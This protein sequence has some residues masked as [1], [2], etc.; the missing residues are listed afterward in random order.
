MG[1]SR[2]F[3]GLSLFTVILSIGLISGTL[4]SDSDANRLI[5]RADDDQ[6][7]NDYLPE[8]TLILRQRLVELNGSALDTS[9]SDLIIDLFDDTRLIATDLIVNQVLGNGKIW[10]GRIKGS[11]SG[12][13]IIS[14]NDDSITATVQ[15][16][17]D[18]YHIRYFNADFSVVRQIDPYEFG[19]RSH[20]L[21][22]TTL[23][24]TGDTEFETEVITLTNQER[25]I[26]NLNSLSIDSNLTT[27]ARQHSIDLADN[28]L[29][30]HIGSD[31]ST[32]FERITDAG[33]DSAY[34]GENV[35]AGYST[36]ELVVEGWMSSSGHR[37]NILNSDFC[38][39]GVGYAYNASSTYQH[40]WTQNF[41][42]K[43]GVTTCEPNASESDDSGELNASEADDST[44]G[45]FIDSLKN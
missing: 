7:Q 40:Y 22:L 12:Q 3:R 19:Q 16:D 33:Y 18:Y 14:Q 39:I 38:D 34:T 42:R 13:I 24:A 2:S 25:S 37:A 9:F 23:K 4:Y 20:I 30:G 29:E 15:T 32:P 8:N 28:D 6:V 36:P 11:S 44:G 21:T 31:G 41:G 5:I 27:S 1:I 10:T 17:E 26:E 43:I 35:A 45:C